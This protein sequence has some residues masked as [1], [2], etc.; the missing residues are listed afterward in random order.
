MKRCSTSLIIGEMNIKPT[1][2][3]HLTPV[4]MA[5]IKKSTNNKCW[6]GYIDKESL[7][8]CWWQFKLVQPLW[9]TAWMFLTKLKTELPDDPAISLLGMYL[10]ENMIQ[11][12][13]HIP[14]FIETLFTIAQTWK[15]SKCPLTEERIKMWYLYKMEY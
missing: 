3:Y 13:M 11:K 15:Q 6:R 14:M 8:H 2:R 9:R 12:D 10:E 5:I 4:R 7:L 1:M